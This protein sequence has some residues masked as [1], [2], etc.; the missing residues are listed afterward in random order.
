DGDTL[1]PRVIAD[2]TNHNGVR[3]DL[4]TGDRVGPIQTGD[5]PQPRPL[6]SKNRAHK[7]VASSFIGDP[8]GYLRR[9]NRGWQEHQTQRE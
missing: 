1:G 4:K 9:K 6:Y 2:I 8:P 7:R 5:C 3:S